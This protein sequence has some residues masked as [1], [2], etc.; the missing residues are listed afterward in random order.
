MLGLLGDEWTL[1]I[2]QRAL[3]GARRYGDFAAAL[4]VSD[5]V[6]SA[7]LRSLSTDDLLARRQYRDNP[8]ARSIC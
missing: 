5:A 1:L 3:L 4:P 2:V 8:R 7:R 6:L